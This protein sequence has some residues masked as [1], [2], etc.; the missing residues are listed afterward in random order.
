MSDISKLAAKA[1]QHNHSMLEK[2]GISPT[3]GFKLFGFLDDALKL[4][5]RTLGKAPGT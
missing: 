3:A 2:E 1:A 5:G 4:G